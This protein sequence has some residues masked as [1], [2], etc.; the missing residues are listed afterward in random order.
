M[1]GTA[2]YDMWLLGAAVRERRQATRRTQDQLAEAASVSSSFVSRLERGHPGAR[3]RKVV[4]VLKAV[5]LEVTDVARFGHEM[6]EME[7]DGIDYRD[8]KT[9]DDGS[10]VTLAEQ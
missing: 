9:A 6:F 5:G 7:Q 3:Y 4:S 10:R 1:D 8:A 2:D